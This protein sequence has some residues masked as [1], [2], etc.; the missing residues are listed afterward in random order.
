[1]KKSRGIARIELLNSEGPVLWAL[2]HDVDEYVIYDKEDGIVD[3]LNQQEIQEFV[4][5]AKIL[6]GEHGP[7]KYTEYPGSMKPDLKKLDEFIGIDT[8]GK[9]Y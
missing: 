1:M 4:H 2:K 5:G 3:I 8:T 6:H 7:Y 9:T